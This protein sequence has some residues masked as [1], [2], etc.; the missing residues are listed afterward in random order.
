[1]GDKININIV[2]ITLKYKFFFFRL[3]IHLLEENKIGLTYLKIRLKNLYFFFFFFQNFRQSYLNQTILYIISHLRIQRG[4][5]ITSKA[6]LSYY[7]LAIL[8][9]RRKKFLSYRKE[10]KRIYQ[11]IY[12]FLGKRINFHI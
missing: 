4:S 3:H 5:F 2:L 10:K 8:Y 1:M 6:C 9:I 12:P 7:T 11:K